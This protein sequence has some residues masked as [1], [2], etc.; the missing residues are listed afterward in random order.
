MAGSDRGH[1]VSLGDYVKLRRLVTVCA[2]NLTQYVADTKGELTELEQAVK[3]LSQAV[4]E[5]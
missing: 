4:E 1:W 3:E 2:E 5:F